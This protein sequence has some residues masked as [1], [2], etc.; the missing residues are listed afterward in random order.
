MSELSKETLTT[1]AK[2]G[3]SG[4]RFFPLPPRLFVFRSLSIEMK[5]KLATPASR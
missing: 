5:R 2:R 1:K 4:H 3:F